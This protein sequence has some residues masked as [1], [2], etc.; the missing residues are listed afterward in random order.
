MAK[1]TDG[2]YLV[3][4][5]H[6]STIFKINGTDGAVIWR[7][8]G[9]HSDFALG[10][11]VRFGFQ[12]HA[13]YFVEDPLGS[14]EVIS[15]FDNSVYGSE[16]AGNGNEIRIN[17]YS[18]GKYI[19]LDHVANKAT[20]VRALEPPAV[21][22]PDLAVGD[23][24]ILTKSQGSLQSLPGSG[25]FVNWGSEGQITEYD[26]QGT[27]IFHAFLGQGFLRDRLQ[28]Y[29]AFRFNW[30][31]YSPEMPAIYAEQSAGQT[32]R[33]FV[34][35]NGDTVTK[36]WRFT[37]AE[38]TDTVDASGKAQTTTVWKEKVV[39]RRGF[40]TSARIQRPEDVRI[41]S[42]KAEALDT[43]GRVLGA[44]SS[45][46]VQKAL[47]KAVGTHADKKAVGQAHLGFGIEL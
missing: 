12:H 3:S 40:E 46:S 38:E 10:E 13:R 9:N 24:P 32:V 15:L 14:G 19:R 36:A 42:V 20:L 44:S 2:H 6:A 47:T 37:W 18:R 26:A 35:W 31:G 16:S 28:N 33:L 23:P 30:T 1:G 5:R 22:V 45:V 25:D 11:G 34:S 7:L 27:P 43:D 17:P 39:S 21:V 4:A 41:V 8:G 29:R